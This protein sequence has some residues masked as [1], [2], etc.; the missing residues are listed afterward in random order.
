MKGPHRAV[1]GFGANLGDRSAT[2]WGALSELAAADGVLVTA[3]SGFR[4]TVALT[5][6]GRDPERPTYLNGVA[7]VQ[8]ERGPGELLRLL[9]SIEEAHGRTRE[10]RWG[11]RTLD[12]DLVDVDG[13][14]LRTPE[15]TLPHPR[16][17]ER[18]FVLAPWLEVDPDARIP[19]L[20]R[21]DRLLRALR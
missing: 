20:G 14:T 2:I 12:L 3:V 9:R 7:L 18:D 1:V 19:G 5:P 17:A 8:S 16:A 21:V 10:V 11:D 6:A 4:E 13:M 15:L